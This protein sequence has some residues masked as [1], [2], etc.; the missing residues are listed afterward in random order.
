[1]IHVWNKETIAQSLFCWT[2][3]QK[4]LLVERC[5]RLTRSR[6]NESHTLKQGGCY[7][8]Y[9]GEVKKI[10]PIEGVIVYFAENGRSDGKTV[11]LSRIREIHGEL[12]N[13]MDEE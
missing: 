7:T 10:D 1:M 11:P 13:Y 2:Y 6:D 4:T 5:H 8:S 3:P 9:T 12:V